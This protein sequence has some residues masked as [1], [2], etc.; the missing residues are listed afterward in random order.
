MRW[1]INQLKPVAKA[2]W[3]LAIPL[4]LFVALLWYIGHDWALVLF[5]AALVGG[6]LVLGWETWSL[7]RA[8]QSI[9]EHQVRTE[10]RSAL[11]AAKDFIEIDPE[12][13]ANTLPKAPRTHGVFHPIHELASHGNNLHDRDTVRDLQNL[14][15]EVDHVKIE[16]TASNPNE[17]KDRLV[18]LQGRVTQELLEMRLDLIRTRPIVQPL[19][20]GSAEIEGR[21]QKS[22]RAVGILAALAVLFY[23][24]GVF[25]P[26]G[27][28]FARLFFL[29]IAGGLLTSAL[30][31]SVTELYLGSQD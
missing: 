21:F 13:F 26:I 7:A 6:T 12:M 9:A 1:T 16:Q 31:V 27:P 11:E 4:A 19:K 30:V 15:A 22:I 29:S 24:I 14:A 5:T 20:P 23:L 28:D 10:I 8:N 18:K 17:T 3:W 2:N 25:Y